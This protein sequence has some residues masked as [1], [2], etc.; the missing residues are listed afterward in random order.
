MKYSKCDVNKHNLIDI[1][2]LIYQTEPEL[3][4]MFF[5]RNKPKAIK[6]IIKLIKK[7]SNSFSYN[8]IFLVF[9]KNK[10]LGIV[11]GSSGKEINKEEERKEITNTLDFFGSMRL[12][13]YEKIILNR[14]LTTKIKA[15]EYYISVLCVNKN[16]QKKG[17][18]KNLVK[19]VK[20]IAQ[21]KK[22]SRIILDVSKDNDIG[23]KLYNKIGFKVY[24]EINHR[25]FFGKICVL[26]MEL[27]LK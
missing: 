26:K 22:C 20:K 12:L 3:S 9:E 19:N 5:G 15:D 13:Y 21:E 11:I 18:G 8:N 27:Y 4:K 2:E 10:V 7:K 16:Y 23:L 1:A 25:F 14:L 6:R 17:I 24:E